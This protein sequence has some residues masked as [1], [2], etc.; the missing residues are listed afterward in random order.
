M[1]RGEKHDLRA[2]RGN[3]LHRKRLA[4]RLAPPAQLR[5]QFGQAAHAGMP[6]A[7]I[8]SRLFNIVGAEEGAGPARILRSPLLR[9]RRP[10]PGRSSEQFLQALLDAP[11][12]V[13]DGVMIRTVSSPASVPATSFQCSASTAAASGCAPP[14]GVF[15]TSMFCAGRISSRNSFSA[16]A[17]AGDAASF[18][19]CGGC[20]RP[21]AFGRFHQPQF[22]QVARERGLRHAHA[23]VDKLAAQLVLVGHG[24]RRAR[25]FRICPCRNR[26]MCAHVVAYA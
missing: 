26:F 3:R 17:R 25:S 15:S 20:E 14:G 6:F 22:A 11:R 12:A 10:V 1:R 8:K 16:R 23:Q 5:K 19:G 7:Q 13:R 4:R 18:F 2:A 9:R 24:L 21:V